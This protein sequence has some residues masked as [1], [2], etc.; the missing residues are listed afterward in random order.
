MAASPRC[1]RSASGALVGDDGVPPDGAEGIDGGVEGD[2]TDH[3]GGARLLA[4]GGRRPD[5]LV[6]T[7]EVD[8][9][10]AGQERVAGLEGGPGP[11][12][13]ARAEGGVELVAGQGQ[14]VGVAGSGRCGASWAA[15]T[16]T[17]TP[18][19]WAAAMIG[20]ERREPARDVGR[21]G[22]G[23]QRRRAG[24]GVECGDDVVDGEGARRC[25]TPRTV[26]GP[27]VPTA[28]GWRGA[29]PRW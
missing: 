16:R 5:H 6:Q 3:V 25:R 11:D 22:D 14:V 28:A 26:G 9:P 2:G 1:S 7:H 20:V 19:S 21:T 10:T 23:Q 4:V 27:P 13:G 24:P 12:Q 8:G 18:R 17:G 29:R 15:S